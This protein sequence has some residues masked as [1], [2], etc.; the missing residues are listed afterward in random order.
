MLFK[1][2]R[3]TYVYGSRLGRQVYTDSRDSHGLGHTRTA[4]R[5]GL[6]RRSKHS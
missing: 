6:V 1:L 5:L 3:T 2:S 4:S